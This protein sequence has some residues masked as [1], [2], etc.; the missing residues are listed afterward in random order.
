M[1]INKLI[2]INLAVGRPGGGKSAYMAYIIAKLFA[3]YQR[4]ERKYPALPKRTMLCD[5]KLSKYIEMREL[6]YPFKQT[7][8]GDLITD[9]QNPQLEFYEN[10]RGKRVNRTRHLIYWSDP[11]QLRYCHVN[12]CWKGNIPHAVHDCD[13]MIDEAANLLPADGWSDTPRWLRKVFSQHR[14]R[15]IRVFA[16]TQDYKGVDINFR[17]MIR[18]AELIQPV[19]KSRDISAS[20]PPVKHIFGIIMVRR[21]DPGQL[22][23]VGINNAEK[24]EEIEIKPPLFAARSFWLNRRLIESY[25]TQQDLPEYKPSQME[26]IVYECEHGE[27]CRDPKHRFKV[28]HQVIA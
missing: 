23:E 6:K 22:E 10:L 27:N 24:L 8:K 2:Q 7:E 21:F 5:L 26:E 19:F 11:R 1:V 25:D 18:R 9:F 12:D 17:R 4:T 14:H 3:Q 28:L 16:N 20:L 13:I 15:G